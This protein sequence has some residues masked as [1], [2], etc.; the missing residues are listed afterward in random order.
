[1]YD[2]SQSDNWYDG[3]NLAWGFGNFR[4]HVYVYGVGDGGASLTSAHAEFEAPI[5]AKHDK[6]ITLQSALDLLDERTAEYLHY[7]VES[8]DL[9]FLLL[10]EK[11]EVDPTDIKIGDV[12]TFEIK[13]GVPV[14]EVILKET[15]SPKRYAYV[16][17]TIYGERSL[18]RM[19]DIAQ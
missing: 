18:M 19:K 13:G 16:V 5:K 15:D 1:M 8:V 12:V 11:Q 4:K 2:V 9:T 14:W 10:S 17:D 7:E 6:M 3:L